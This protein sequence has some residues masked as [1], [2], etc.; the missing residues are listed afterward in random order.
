MRVL[1]WAVPVDDRQHPIGD[2]PV[3][4]VDVQDSDWRVMYVWT[5]EADADP[6]VTGRAAQVYGTGQ[7]LPDYIGRGYFLGTAVAGPFVWHVF[8]TREVMTP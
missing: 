8:A 7:K 2:G 4:H 3:L 1:K 6:V 5:L